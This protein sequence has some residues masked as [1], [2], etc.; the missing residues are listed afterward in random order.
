M[1]AQQY[2]NTLQQGISSARFDAYR[3]R[4]DADDLDAVAR[5]VWNVAL[6]EALYPALQALEVTLRNSLHSAISAR[7]D[8]PMWF[9]QHP[10]FL[11][12]SELD[13]ISAAKDEVRKERKPLEAGRIVTELSFGFWT[14]LLDVRYEPTLWPALLKRAFP[15]MPRRIRTRRFLSKRLN[16]VRKLRNRVFHHES[17]LNWKNPGL[18]EQHAQILDLIQWMNPA[19][20]DTVVLFDRFPT[21]YS[22]GMQHYRALLDTYVAKQAT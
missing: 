18:L 1:Q 8:D 16:Q 10:S 5:Y 11:Q 21:V 7:S 13:R 3:R 9:D 15:A 17:I 12:Q 19:A 4:A 22:S 14:S 20:H 2:V 6:S